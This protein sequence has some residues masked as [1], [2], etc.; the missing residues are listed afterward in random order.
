MMELTQLRLAR[1]SI[2]ISGSVLASCGQA[3]DLP[4]PSI[5]PELESMQPVFDCIEATPQ[6]ANS[7]IQNCAKKA[8]IDV[9]RLPNEPKKADE[10]KPLIVA[11]WMFFDQDKTKR[12]SSKSFP[13]MID[14][15]RCVETNA[16][17]DR[18]FS[19]RT[20]NGVAEA[21]QR[22]EVACMEHPFALSGL[23][24][25]KAAAISDPRERMLAKLIANIATTY[26]LE[27][28][29]WYPDELRPCFK[30][31]D[32]RPPSVGCSLNPQPKMASP[33]PPT[34]YRPQ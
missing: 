33:P 22:A 34:G 21:Q 26:A 27:I 15:A 30:Y 3:K 32:G 2:F 23:S 16:Y 14:Y 18:T 31:L 24:P 8:G 13:S 28:N 10:F 6:G 17:A 29:G 25:E 20:A 5:L 11:S 12:L 1:L 19:N 4:W 7:E 9:D